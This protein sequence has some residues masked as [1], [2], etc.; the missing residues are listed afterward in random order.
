MN[1]E[2]VARFREGTALT[3][4][5]SMSVAA[6][7]C[8]DLLQSHA[9]E[10][11][12]FINGAK[13]T[14]SMTPVEEDERILFEAPDGDGASGAGKSG[15]S[16]HKVIRGE[17][18]IDRGI[19][20]RLTA[21]DPHADMQK[22]EIRQSLCSA[23]R[24]VMALYNAS[25]DGRPEPN[26]AEWRL[27]LPHLQAERKIMQELRSFISDLVPHRGL[28]LYPYSDG[29][30]GVSDACGTLGASLVASA[31]DGV[32]SEIRSLLIS[33]DCVRMSGDSA[34]P[35]PELMAAFN[36]LLFCPV[37]VSSNTGFLIVMEEP[38]GF[39]SHFGDFPHLLQRQAS[40]FVLGLMEQVRVDRDESAPG[41]RVRFLERIGMAPDRESI[42]ES[43][44]SAIR[45]VLHAPTVLCL[46]EFHRGSRSISVADCKCADGKEC[47]SP[48]WLKRDTEF[49][50]ALRG[51]EVILSSTSG[52]DS[53]GKGMADRGQ[54]P[55]PIRCYVPL[56]SGDEGASVVYAESIREMSCPHFRGMLTAVSMISRARYREI[57]MASQ[58]HKERLDFE[59]LKR[60]I[61]EYSSDKVNFDDLKNSADLILK[62]YSK[63]VFVAFF[64]REG[65]MKSVS[66]SARGESWKNVLQRSRIDYPGTDFGYQDEIVFD[67][68]GCTDR[69]GKSL[70]QLTEGYMGDDNY[71]ITVLFH[72]DGIEV[73]SMM[74][75]VS[76]ESVDEARHTA[77]ILRTLFDYW[78][79][80]LRSL[81]QKAAEDDIGAVNRELLEELLVPGSH[82]T[83]QEFAGSFC[84]FLSNSFG[85]S[86]VSFYRLY[87]QKAY[88]LISFFPV[89]RH[90]NRELSLNNLLTINFLN[91]GAKWHIGLN[92][93]DSMLSMLGTG[94]G[95][96]E[97]VMIVPLYSGNGDAL[98]DG[99]II[100]SAPSESMDSMNISAL[101]HATDLFSRAISFHE[102]FLGQTR[103]AYAGD[104]LIEVLLDAFRAEDNGWAVSDAEIAKAFCMMIGR[105]LD[106][107][108]TAAYA[109]D[110]EKHV[111]LPVASF[112]SSGGQDVDVLEEA[113][114]LLHNGVAAK[115]DDINFSV[116]Q[117]TQ[118]EVSEHNFIRRE[119][120]SHLSVLS[121][122]GRN[123]RSETVFVAFHTGEPAVT[124][125][126]ISESSRLVD[127][128]CYVV[129]NRNIRR[130]TDETLNALASELRIA[131]NIS[132]TFDLDIILNQTV[133]EVKYFAR[134]DLVAVFLVDDSGLM[135][136][137]SVSSN[138]NVDR[139]ALRNSQ[140][141]MVSDDR[142][143]GLLSVALEAGGHFN[144][145]SEKICSETISRLPEDFK[146]VLRLLNGAETP[147]SIAGTPISFA[148]RLLGILVC[149]NNRSEDSFSE[150]HLD[151]IDAASVLLST[152]IENSRNFRAT[153]D[154]LNKLGKL[155]TLRSNFS[156]I[157]AHELRT[158]LTSI[159][160]YIELMKMG[161]VG[162]FTEQEMM[163]IENLLASIS[164]L[165]EIVN[166]MLEFTRM[167]ALML[168][169]EMQ[170]ISIIPLIEEVCSVVSPQLLSKSIE[171]KIEMEK[172]LRKVT[173]NAG[174]IK[175]AIN[176]LVTNAIKYNIPGGSI[177]IAARNDGDGI[178]LSVSDTGRGIPEED[179]PYVFDRYH[180][181]DSSIL[182]TGAGFRL[183]LP[184][185]KMIVERHGGRI[186]AESRMGKGSTFNIFLPS[187][188]RIQTD[189]W[190]NDASM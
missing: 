34:K 118:K 160:V 83:I 79:T 87:S 85:F 171:L 147:K 1:T 174:L 130:K 86:S 3:F 67:R 114:T 115:D 95:T 164:E 11:S 157:A 60:L 152:G 167:E 71:T 5:R 75:V 179:L 96:D 74:Y 185:S 156:S 29:V 42:I 140:G 120:V 82:H 125:K 146:A 45:Y 64:R 90:P 126:Q 105:I 183:G 15:F 186:W 143:S 2:D 59:S 55:G 151:Y 13:V 32:T 48:E 128:F 20:C 25:S 77:G 89:T 7:V 110:R 181:V 150:W 17:F 26:H 159:R 88:E 70:L 136:V 63:F 65:V 58:L 57:S 12:I 43:A 148:G 66:H 52:E 38:Q 69:L 133:E 97:R 141:W 138:T 106:A 37:A 68:E 22:D 123:C 145:R 139:E 50:R 47:P 155:D 113:G 172:D 190:L 119:G 109:V 39:A 104:Q 10:L 121:P 4:A 23:V 137:A 169:T 187:Q 134:C 81:E 162:K 91:R 101:K 177:H 175:R 35:Y 144:I 21:L 6:G 31:G 176:N 41:G 80:H 44:L 49:L 117:L 112:S 76:S 149:F 54:E 107:R 72:R 98:P 40:R 27:P 168:E 153:Y 73:D 116:L 189:E 173:A 135:R 36:G 180:V 108:L 33:G 18:E 93:G 182:H 132:S 61:S 30:L 100:L 165:N 103:H 178:L 51:Q 94:E 131:R 124:S 14:G 24:C 129:E 142:N 188:R 8:K 122:A 56:L 84:R 16:P 158:P 19:S 154:A 99:L 127:A 78:T 166:N 161:K 46:L 111:A 184:I 9:C 62:A 28:A 163:N 53:A 170:S 102:S 92:E